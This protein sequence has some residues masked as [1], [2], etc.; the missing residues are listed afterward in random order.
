MEEFL[1]HFLSPGEQE[2]MR[3]PGRASLPLSSWIWDHDQQ[4][5][6]DLVFTAEHLLDC[7]SH[8][9][10]TATSVSVG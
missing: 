1:V 4:S 6:L 8:P 10:F 2:L 5:H 9:H 7:Q 3:N